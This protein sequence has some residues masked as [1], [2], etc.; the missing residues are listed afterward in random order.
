MAAGAVVLVSMTACGG[1]SAASEATSSSTKSGQVETVKVAF[2]PAS[3][4]APLF[5]GMKDGIFKDHG[6]NLELV[7]QTDIAA[8]ISGL[9]SGQYDFGFATVVH[10]INAR[11]NHIP[12]KAIATP[13]GQQAPEEADD[14]GNALVAG[15]KSGI[16]DA[17]DLG[18]KTLGVIGLSSLNTLAAQELA[19][20]EGV[21]VS[22]IKLVQM[23]F[24]QMPAALAAGDVDAA[25]V[26]SP[27][28][29]EA[30]A[31]GSKVIA[32]PNVEL[33]ANKAVG[34]FLTSEK[35]IAEK[36]N[37][38]EGFA[39]GMVESQK[40]AAEHVDDARATLVDQMKLTP[41]A[42][43][44]ATWCTTCDPALD[45]EGLKTVQGL[46]KKFAGLKDTPDVN[47]YVWKPALSY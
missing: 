1:G 21:D 28:I 27:F 33:F 46:L 8:I 30:L 41:E 35:M 36:E 40:H 9:A 18:G 20:R 42:A 45:T 15:P 19:S 5:L 22:T 24:G 31:D 17:G 10:L 44:K 12:V 29:A 37:L 38:V 3:Q 7:P 2:N 4:F 6:L 14:M 16:K 39:K 26:Q 11:D 34:L 43:A 13:D 32:K 25:V 47:S 23:P